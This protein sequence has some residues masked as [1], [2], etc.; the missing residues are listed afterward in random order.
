MHDD[1]IKN[2]NECDCDED[3]KCGCSY[4]NNVNSSACGCDE[5]D[6]NCSCL[7]TDKETKN[8]IIEESICLC[9]SNA[10]CSCNKI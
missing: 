2:S 8:Y 4:P 5:N 6:N 3:N 9:D 10:D 7:K 1:F